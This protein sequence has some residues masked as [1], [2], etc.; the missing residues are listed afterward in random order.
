[1]GDFCFLFWV[2]TLIVLV[3]FT[4]NNVQTKGAKALKTPALVI[5]ATVALYFMAEL[6]LAM[7]LKN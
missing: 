5:V 3:V 2:V 6:V 1:M 7:V 4:I